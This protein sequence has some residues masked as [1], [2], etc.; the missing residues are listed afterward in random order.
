MFDAL[1]VNTCG[2]DT[3]VSWFPA[4]PSR[5]EPTRHI[6]NICILPVYIICILVKASCPPLPRDQCWWWVVSRCRCGSGRTYC[7][8][9]RRRLSPAGGDTYG[10]DMIS[11]AW[12]WLLFTSHMRHEVSQQLT[13]FWTG[14][15]NMRS[16]PPKIQPT[17]LSNTAGL[18]SHGSGSEH[19]QAVS[20][21]DVMLA[22]WSLCHI[23]VC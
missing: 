6:C 16:I 14:W 5:R 13:C 22:A 4:F 19:Q 15:G 10:I 7:S 3:T 2:H 9:P 8:A 23:S 18:E 21:S 20:V 17:T 12:S 1:L 11:D